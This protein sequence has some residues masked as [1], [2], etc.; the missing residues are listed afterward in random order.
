[1]NNKE[2]AHLWANQSRESASGSHFYFNG[3]TV[4]S[5]GS[6]FPIARHYRGAVLFTSR[7]HSVTTARHKGITWGACHHLPVFTVSDV[8]TNPSGK[9]VRE[10]GEQ[11]QGL[12]LKAGK[13]RNPDNALSVLE[14]AVNEANRF[15]ERFGFKTRFTMPDNLE[16]LRAKARASAERERK[17]KAAREAKFERD[18]QE[19]IAKWLAG[20]MVSV[21]YAIGSVYL[22]VR[23][24]VGDCPATDGVPMMETSKGAKVP[25]QEAQKAFRFAVIM[26]ERGWH[27]NGDK[28]Q[29]GDYQLDAV[30]AQGVVAGCHRIA[31]PEIERFAK[32]QGWL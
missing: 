2:V 1:M 22:R 16:E 24:F 12:A 9:D 11:I 13:A 14:S 29:V 5:Y 15:C 21:P 10:Y 6:H 19:T 28:F 32:L 7:D 18:A 8:M 4:Y 20:E 17:A 27:R 26:R 3:D 25:L 30:N 31:W 23:P